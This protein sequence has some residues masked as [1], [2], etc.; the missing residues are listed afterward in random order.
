MFLTAYDDHVHAVQA[1]RPTLIDPYGAEGHEEFFAVAVEVFFEKPRA[2][3][4]A[5]PAGLW[6]LAKLF[7]LD[8]AQWQADG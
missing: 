8:P 1:G 2:L 7:G 3:K 6:P 4:S 5:H